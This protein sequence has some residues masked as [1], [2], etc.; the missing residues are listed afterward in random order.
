VLNTQSS[1]EFKVGRKKEALKELHN[2]FQVL[3]KVRQY[4][5]VEQSSSNS[6]RLLRFVDML[7]LV[8]V[9]HK[10]VDGVS[11]VILVKRDS[12]GGH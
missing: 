11:F 10:Q 4:P 1:K 9:R 12:G 2:T 8:H 7:V 6:C 5:A 3:T